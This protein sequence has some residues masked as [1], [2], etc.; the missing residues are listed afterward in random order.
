M[1]IRKV[2]NK[3]ETAAFQR[4]LRAGLEQYETTAA[5]AGKRQRARHTP[6]DL[7][8]ER[9]GIQK[10]WAPLADAGYTTA[11]KV[12]RLIEN[13]CARPTTIERAQLSIFAL[14]RSA[15]AASWR[16]AHGWGADKWYRNLQQ[17]RAN[18]VPW[19]AHL[20]SPTEP[21][22][23]LMAAQA[24]IL[25]QAVPVI[26]AAV[27]QGLYDKKFLTKKQLTAATN[28]VEAGLR[29]RVSSWNAAFVEWVQSA[30]SFEDVRVEEADEMQPE[31][32]VLH[33][34]RVK[35]VRPGESEPPGRAA[36]H[37]EFIEAVLLR[38][39]ARAE[40]KR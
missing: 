36:T 4:F 27:A 20:I 35:V 10:T 29:R 19:A 33:R 31:G 24:A 13:A 34:R 38:A 12:G 40:K 28:V 11:A 21:S 16:K 7:L 30:Q 22:D 26:A 15:A 32:V 2:M 5:K 3:K 6:L 37:V 23:P 18:G 39:N 1:P 8:G 17:L 9:L 14:E 25:P